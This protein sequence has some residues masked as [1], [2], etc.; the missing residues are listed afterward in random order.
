MATETTLLSILPNLSIGVIS[1][2]AL[3]YVTLKFVTY[4]KEH[5]NIF[6]KEIK[7]RESSLRQLEAEVRTSVMTQLQEN[8]KAFERVL[9]HIQK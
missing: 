6:L 9:N 8:T 3:V 5:N 2:L 4:Q 1:V 7:E